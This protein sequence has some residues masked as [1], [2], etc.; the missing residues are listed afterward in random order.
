MVAC[1]SNAGAQGRRLAEISWQFQTSSSG[2][3]G[4][5]RRPVAGSVVDHHNL[6]N[7]LPRPFYDISDVRGFIESRN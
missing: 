3:P 2:S 6:G 5:V 4:N 7:I 1:E